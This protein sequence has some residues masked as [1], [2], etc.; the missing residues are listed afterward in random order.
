[1]KRLRLKIISTII[2]IL[3]VL[4]I[5][6]L[7]PSQVPLDIAEF[8]SLYNEPNDVTEGPLKVYHLGHS[9]VG[10]DMPIMLQQLAGAEHTFSSQLGWGTPLKAHFEEEIEINGYEEENDHPN[11]QHIRLLD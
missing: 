2:A 1:M 11:F 4:G 7:W 9:L 8:N 3:G 6:R 5:T 10:R